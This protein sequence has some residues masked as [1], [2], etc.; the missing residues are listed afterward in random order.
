MFGLG[1]QELLIIFVIVLFLFGGAKIPE[2]LR[3]VGRGV[4]ELQKGLEEG[5][6]TV[7]R[8]M[9]EDSK[10]E[11]DERKRSETAEREKREEEKVS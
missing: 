4:G 10:P 7:N 6:R 9:V 2:L 8:A 5:K 1:S 11:L 3:G